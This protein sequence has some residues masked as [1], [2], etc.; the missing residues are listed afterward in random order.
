MINKTL[1]GNYIYFSTF[2]KQIEKNTN[3]WLRAGSTRVTVLRLVVRHVFLTRCYRVNLSAGP[4]F[5]QRISSIM[6][7]R[8]KI[9]YQDKWLGTENTYRYESL[10]SFPNK[11]TSISIWVTSFFNNKKISLERSYQSAL[12]NSFPAFYST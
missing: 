1:A 10:T 6:L 7:L 2:L 11:I 3:F 12:G 8:G 5:I 9:Y 4:N